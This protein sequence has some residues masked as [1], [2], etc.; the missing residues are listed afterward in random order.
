MSRIIHRVSH[1]LCKLMQR[2]IKFPMEEDEQNYVKRKF[3]EI[4]NFP[5]VLGCIDGTL[6]AIKSPSASDN[7]QVY[8]CRKGYHAINVMITTSHTLQITALNAK[9]PGSCH[10]SFVLQQSLLSDV[11]A[12]GIDGWL[13]GDSGYALAPTLL[14]PLESPQTSRERRYNRSHKITRSS[15]ERAIGIWKARFGCLNHK[16]NGCLPFSPARSSTVVCAT[17]VLHNL[18][19]ERNLPDPVYNS[20]DTVDDDNILLDNAHDVSGIRVRQNLINQ[21]FA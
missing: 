9:F 1:R 5:G 21:R 20:D 13:L 15:V 8:V 2:Y 19:R 7:E 12:S 6:I 17:A 10:D 18:A 11:L 4:S 3:A 16:L 14:T